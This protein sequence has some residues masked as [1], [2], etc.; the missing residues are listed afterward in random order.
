VCEKVAARTLA[1]P[2]YGSMSE[3]EVDR[4]TH[5]LKEELPSLPRRYP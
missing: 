4:V 3:E 1:L 5:E 2:F